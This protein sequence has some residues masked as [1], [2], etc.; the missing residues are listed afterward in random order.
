MVVGV[1]CCSVVV[2]AVAVVAVAWGPPRPNLTLAKRPCAALLSKG[3][4]SLANFR[5]GFLRYSAIEMRGPHSYQRFAY[6]CRVSSQLTPAPSLSIAYYSCIRCR[7]SGTDP[8]HAQRRQLTFVYV[9]D[10]TMWSALLCCFFW[11]LPDRSVR[12][13]LSTAS[14]L[15]LALTRELCFSLELD[16]RHLVS[17][18][19]LIKTTALTPREFFQLAL[20]LL[21]L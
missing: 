2:G 18:R 6:G 21:C 16:A 14:L 13:R 19:S 7:G 9:L 8:P 15:E 20:L 3:R 11:C 17:L 1:V 5:F 10:L 12:R 4:E